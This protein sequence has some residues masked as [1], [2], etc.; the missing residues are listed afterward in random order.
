MV[1]KRRAYW[2][3]LIALG[4]LLSQ[5]ACEQPSPASDD[6]SG[7]TKKKKKKGKKKKKKKDE[8]EDEDRGPSDEGAPAPP[9]PPPPPP[10]PAPVPLPPPPAPAP[11]APPPSGGNNA[12][13][14]GSNAAAATFEAVAEGEW[15]SRLGPKMK[16]G[17][18][19]AH[20][21]YRGP[22]GPSPRSLFAVVKHDDETYHAMI[23]GDDNKGWRAGP[24]AE[25]GID[26]PDKVVAVSFFDADGDGTTDALV[27]ARYTNPAGRVRITYYKN[28]LI[29]WTSMGPRRMLN[30]EGRIRSL[31][32]VAAV[33]KALGR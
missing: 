8:D 19:V 4:L 1:A 24:L 28:A 9:E 17:S 15:V 22:F 26:M 12:P 3:G 33:R 29:K 31:E 30:I 13:S 25:P 18:H 20:T 23:M 2:A 7:E 32:S 21:V 16:A 5:P 27:M 10:A 14:G 11:P 6:D